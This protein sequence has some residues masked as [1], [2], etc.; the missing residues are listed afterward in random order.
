MVQLFLFKLVG[1]SSLTLVLPFRY[2]NPFS[3]PSLYLT[4]DDL[5]TLVNI[6]WCILTSFLP[7][8][9]FHTPS[10]NDSNSYLF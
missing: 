9:S 4:Y 2:P 1:N 8:G 3:I 5:S 10:L 6:P 7:T